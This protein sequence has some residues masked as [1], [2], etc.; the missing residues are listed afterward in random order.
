MEEE[1]ER[2]RAQPDTVEQEIEDLKQQI[3]SHALHR[4]SF[5]HKYKVPMDGT[6]TNCIE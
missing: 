6:A 1:L 3:S 5:I 2:A 4:A